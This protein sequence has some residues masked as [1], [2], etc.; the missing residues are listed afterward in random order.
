MREDVE[1]EDVARLHVA[2]VVEKDPVGHPG[3][4]GDAT[5]DPVARRRQGRE[6]HDAGAFSEHLIGV[7]EVNRHDVEADAGNGDIADGN[8][9]ILDDRLN[10]R[11]GVGDAAVVLL[12]VAVGVVLAN[13]GV[14]FFIGRVQVLAVGPRQLHLVL[15]LQVVVH[16]R[17]QQENRADHQQ[18]AKHPLQHI[19]V[20]GLLLRVG[21]NA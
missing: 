5:G 18:G 14:A 2:N 9:L 16:Q 12:G 6:G 13:Q 3:V 17:R 7:A 15:G 19:S 1:V 4:A 10:R 20:R 8:A 11:L 21:H